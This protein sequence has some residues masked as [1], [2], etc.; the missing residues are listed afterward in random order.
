MMSEH[1]LEHWPEELYLPGPMIDRTNW[2]QWK[3]EGEKTFRDRALE[4]IAECLS[5]Y[6]V[7]PLEEKL[8]LEI[9]DMFQRTA[10]D[11]GVVLPSFH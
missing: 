6:E 7:E 8:H 5:N 2:D 4:V 3:G 9:R 11:R 10:L 1:T